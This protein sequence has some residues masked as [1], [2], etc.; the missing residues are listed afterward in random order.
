MNLLRARGTLR[1]EKE[2]LSPVDRRSLCLKDRNQMLYE[3]ERE[4]TAASRLETLSINPVL[5]KQ[6]AGGM[7]TFRREE[8][9]TD[10]S[11]G[12]PGG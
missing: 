6:T 7:L 9:P 12:E 11:L 2:G 5:L 10:R 4:K 1:R 3:K 8:R